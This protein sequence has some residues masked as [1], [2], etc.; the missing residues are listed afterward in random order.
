MTDSD[1]SPETMTRTAK[2]AIWIAA[3]VIACAWMW[4]AGHR[5]V[6]SIGPVM[7]RYPFVEW[8][9]LRISRC[10]APELLLTVIG[11]PIYLV[12]LVGTPF[13]I[14]LLALVG[15][16][17][18]ER[19]PIGQPLKRFTIRCFVGWLVAVAI[20]VP[21]VCFTQERMRKRPELNTRE[22]FVAQAQKAAQFSFAVSEPKI[23]WGKETIEASVNHE[24]VDTVLMNVA[25]EHG[26]GFVVIGMRKGRVVS[27]LIHFATLNGWRLIINGRRIDILHPRTRFQAPDLVPV[28]QIMDRQEI[29]DLVVLAQLLHVNCEA[30]EEETGKELRYGEMNFHAICLMLKNISEGK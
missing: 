7:Q 25:L 1:K 5:A 26:P 10:I 11:I 14:G 27:Y 24:R 3:A 18:L 21:M 6:A 23:Y 19:R 20:T 13:M 28:A 29:E 4:Y 30:M 9:F 17:L 8:S 12:A 2:Y 22:M 15:F 16:R